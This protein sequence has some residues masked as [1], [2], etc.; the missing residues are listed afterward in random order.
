MAMTKSQ[1][2]EEARDILASAIGCAYYR[3]EN[4]SGL[5][6][7]DRD[8]ITQYINTLGERACKAIGTRYISY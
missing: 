3:L 4:E 7:E 5:S 6:Q 1:A 2:K 8:L